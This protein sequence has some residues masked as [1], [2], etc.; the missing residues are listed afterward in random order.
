LV[1]FSNSGQI[2]QRVPFED[3]EQFIQ[4]AVQ[5]CHQNGKPRYYL[6]D[7]DHGTV[8]IQGQGVIS[9]RNGQ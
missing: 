1:R 8:R 3:W 5:W 6:E 9:V 2:V 4:Q 7:W